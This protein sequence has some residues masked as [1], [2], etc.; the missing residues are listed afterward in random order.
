MLQ[1]GRLT[2]DNMSLRKESYSYFDFS[3][4]YGH[5]TTMISPFIFMLIFIPCIILTCLFARMKRKQ[6]GMSLTP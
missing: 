6:A 4:V 3:A 2:V 1:D 5:S